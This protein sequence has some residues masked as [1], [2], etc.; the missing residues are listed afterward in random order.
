MQE[1]LSAARRAMAQSPSHHRLCYSLGM[2]TPKKSQLEK[3]QTRHIRAVRKYR[4]TCKERLGPVG[5][6][7]FR[8]FLNLHGRL[9]I[10]STACWAEAL[11]AIK[12]RKGVGSVDSLGGFRIIDA[13]LGT[14]EAGERFDLTAEEVIA[15]CAAE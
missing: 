1:A 13:I 10:S 6:R 7:L 11:A 9:P 2:P 4:K 12:S 15:Y 5:V 3:D 8:E 14:I